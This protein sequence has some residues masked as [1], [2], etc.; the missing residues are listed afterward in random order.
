MSTTHDHDH[1]PIEA[2][3]EISEF[4]VLE[5]GDSRAGDREGRDA[6]RPP[7]FYVLESTPRCTT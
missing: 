6:E 2:A 4:D 5:T 1:A 3:E 7:Y